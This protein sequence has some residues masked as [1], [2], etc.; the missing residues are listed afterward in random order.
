MTVDSA[1]PPA[2][3]SEAVVADLGLGRGAHPRSSSGAV[4]QI[5]SDHRISPPD[6]T[7]EVTRVLA[8]SAT[9]PVLEMTDDAGSA[10]KG[11]L[12]TLLPELSDDAIDALTSR[13]FWYTHW[14][15]GGTPSLP[16]AAPYVESPA[17]SPAEQTTPDG[18]QY[19]RHTWSAGA[20]Y[21]KL[22]R[23]RDFTRGCGRR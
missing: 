16:P 23:G 19:W 7:R 2:L 20:R 5:A 22:E 3:I 14:N 13:A 6:L 4:A 17:T 15:A 1:P 21:F 10:F 12:R 8:V 18:V 11:K 9:L